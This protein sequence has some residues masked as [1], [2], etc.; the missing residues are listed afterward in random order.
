ML[1]SL[2]CLGKYEVAKAAGG[3]AGGRGEGRAE[4]QA[5]AAME[6]GLSHVLDKSCVNDGIGQKCRKKGE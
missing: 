6:A 1:I 3:G 5:K 4:E 2:V